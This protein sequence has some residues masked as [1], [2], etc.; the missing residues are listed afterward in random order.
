LAG[1]NF[2]SSTV[3]VDS[4]SHAEI[5]LFRFLNNLIYNTTLITPFAIFQA[6]IL[7]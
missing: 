4:D 3:Y 5:K 6:A 7:L 2:S 1:D